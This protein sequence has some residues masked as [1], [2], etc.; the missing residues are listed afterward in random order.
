[1]VLEELGSSIAR[2][3]AQL[4]NANVIDQNVLNELLKQI[5]KSLLQADVNIQLVAQLRKNIV[6]A[7]NLKE[8]AQGINKKRVIEDVCANSKILFFVNHLFVNSKILNF[9]S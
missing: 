1:M 8:M 3:L 5:G 9:L 2:S 4:R 6:A 7:V